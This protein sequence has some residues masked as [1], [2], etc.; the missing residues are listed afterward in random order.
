MDS[1]YEFEDNEGP[2][3]TGVDENDKEW[4]NASEPVP[5]SHNP[6]RVQ[7]TSSGCGGGV[8]QQTSDTEE[9]DCEPQRSGIWAMAQVLPPLHAPPSRD[10]G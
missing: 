2:S 8:C 4:V 7:Q 3:L 10:M 1:W 6:P 5:H 9:G